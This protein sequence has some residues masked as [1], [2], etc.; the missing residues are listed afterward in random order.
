MHWGAV[1]VN[2]P[3]SAA[4]YSVTYLALLAVS[5]GGG[6][7]HPRASVRM[8]CIVGR[9]LAIARIYVVLSYLL[10][11]AACIERLRVCLAGCLLLAPWLCCSSVTCSASRP[12]SCR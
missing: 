8:S 9:C 2:R 3:G 6:A 5:G 4:M 7:W 12:S 1:V 11:T 10:N